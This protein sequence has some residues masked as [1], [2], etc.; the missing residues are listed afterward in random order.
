[1]CPKLYTRLL[2]YVLVLHQQNLDSQ[3]ARRFLSQSNK[4][5]KRTCEKQRPER[6][7]VLGV[8]KQFLFEFAKCRHAFAFLHND[9]AHQGIKQAC[10]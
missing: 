6:F 3:M 7:I 4:I 5:A 10:Q 9:D 1:M 8:P 2:D